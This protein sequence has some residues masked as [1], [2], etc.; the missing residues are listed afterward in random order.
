MKQLVIRP[1][2]PKWEL[3]K[4]IKPLGTVTKIIVHYSATHV[5][6]RV[7]V[8]KVRN[9]H[10]DRGCKDIGYHWVVDRDGVVWEGRPESLQ[11]AHCREYN[12]ESIGVCWLGGLDGSGS[13]VGNITKAQKRSM[14]ALLLQLH[15]RY[16]DAMLYGHCDLE[17]TVC[18]MLDVRKMWG[19]IFKSEE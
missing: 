1:R 2:N 13:P 11:G 4:G 17:N 12:R 9:A 3:P 18:P 15:R 7:T 6:R 16:P 8:D 14:E 10:L 5:S 19:K